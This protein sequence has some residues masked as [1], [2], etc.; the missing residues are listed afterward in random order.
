MEV[1]VKTI[2]STRQIHIV[3]LKCKTSDM[4]L[5]PVPQFIDLKA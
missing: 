5:K 4:A 2:D 3:K 1:L